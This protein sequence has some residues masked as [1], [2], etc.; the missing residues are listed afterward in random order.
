M[1]L[2]NRTPWKNINCPKLVWEILD[3]VTIT[4]DCI[5]VTYCNVGLTLDVNMA[6]TLSWAEE[7][8]LDAL[9]TA[10]D[11]SPVPYSNPEAIIISPNLT[12]YTVTVDNTGVATATPL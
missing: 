12:Q 4:T 1:A 3:D 9:I 7:T 6:G 11:D 5:W 10:H 2:Y 8:Q